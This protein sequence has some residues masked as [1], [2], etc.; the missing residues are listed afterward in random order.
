MSE[1]TGPAR[2]AGRLRGPNE[3]KPQGRPWWHYVLGATA[4]AALVGMAWGGYAIWFALTHVRTSYAR[5]TGLVVNVAAKTDTRVQRVL[6]VSGVSTP[7]F[8][9]RYAPHDFRGM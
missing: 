3:R 8:G 5:V 2:R 7:R 6:E 1:T 4:L 9:P